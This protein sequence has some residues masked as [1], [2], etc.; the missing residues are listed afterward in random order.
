[1]DSKF[2]ELRTKFEQEVEKLNEIEKDRTRY[3]SNRQQLES[4]LTEN[5]MVKEELV[6]LEPEANVFKLIGPVL[7]KQDMQEAKENVQKRLDYITTEIKRV[8]SAI[9]DSTKKLEAQKERCE[10]KQ[11]D[12]RTYMTSKKP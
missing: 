3:L 10:E 4:Q 9:D 12:L 7:V 8:E 2:Q 5:N 11:A 6:L 1:M